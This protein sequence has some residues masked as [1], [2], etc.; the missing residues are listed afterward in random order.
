MSKPPSYAVPNNHSRVL[1]KITEH[2]SYHGAV[3]GSVAESILRNHGG[4]CFLTRYS[5][6]KSCYRLSVIK[7]GRVQHFQ[8]LHSFG[9]A[10]YEIE[11]AGITFDDINDLLAHYQSHP[12]DYAIETIGVCVERNSKHKVSNSSYQNGP[13]M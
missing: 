10:T 3:T 4:N 13:K 6:D 12:L 5:E 9:H 8:L 7:E 2:P 11:G 1:R